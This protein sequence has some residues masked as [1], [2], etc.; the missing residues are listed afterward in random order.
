MNTDL[1]RSRVLVTGG[2]GFIGRYLV[3]ALM[4]R[5][6]DV[7]ILSR[8]PSPA[9]MK[10]KTVAGDLTRPETLDDVCRGF[11]VVFHLAGDAHAIDRVD[12]DNER[13]GWRTTVEGTS[14]L[15]D[16]AIRAGVSR[17]LFFS[18]VNAMGEGGKVC[19]DETAGGTRRAD[20]GR[21]NECA[22]RSSE[23]GRWEPVLV[24]Q[25]RERDGRG[26]ESLSRR[27]GREL[28]RDIVWKGQT[29]GGK[30]RARCLSARASINR[31]PSAHGIW[32]R[33]QGKSAAHDPGDCAR[34]FPA[35]A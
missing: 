7:T 11:R 4:Q 32:A 23:Q 28:A 27:D 30:N 18:S 19:L 6:A 34:T 25:Q 13:L 1:L 33:L 8:H 22:W 10:C 2:S 29:G 5:G 21:G 9:G 15:V 17:F 12:D 16:Q 31:S 14:A 35:P 20:E 24:F 3:D 26:R